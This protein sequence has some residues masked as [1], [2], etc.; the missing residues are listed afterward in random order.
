MV[1]F[2]QQPQGEVLLPDQGRPEAAKAE[3][4]N[5][6]HLSAIIAEVMQNA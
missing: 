2:G 1:G 5:W 3:Q 4:R 6:D